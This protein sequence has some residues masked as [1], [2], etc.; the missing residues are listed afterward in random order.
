MDKSLENTI[1]LFLK[2]K[3]KKDKGIPI[4]LHEEGISTYE[5]NNYTIKESN[6]FKAKDGKYYIRLMLSSNRQFEPL[7]KYIYINEKNEVVSFAEFQYYYN[8]ETYICNLE[9]K[10]NYRQKGLITNAIL[11]IEDCS[12]KY[13]KGK[14]LKLLCMKRT[15][16]KENENRNLKFYKYMGFKI[17]ESEENYGEFIHME[18][19]LSKKTDKKK[20][21]I[22]N[23]NLGK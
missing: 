10:E 13:N 17:N 4:K 19:D 7:Q 21:I 12:R 22:N 23:K 15:G 5:Y 9:T 18:K 8:D 11:K 14:P 2:Y 16:D 3:E 1:K 20:Y 6:L